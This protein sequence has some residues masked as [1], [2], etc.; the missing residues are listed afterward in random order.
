VFPAPIKAAKVDAGR[1]PITE[2]D[3]KLDPSLALVVGDGVDPIPSTD[4]PVC[5][6]LVTDS[7]EKSV[8]A[9]KTA[10]SLDI[11]KFSKLTI[12][13][14]EA[15]GSAYATLVVN[16]PTSIVVI[17]LAKFLFFIRFLQSFLN[18]QKTKSIQH[19]IILKTLKI[20]TVKKK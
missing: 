6:L 2:F 16:V 9:S 19:A 18:L 20:Q 3:T 13:C 14:A 17:T 5:W 7:E 15:T 12:A 11:V 10:P 1:A 8:A 4:A